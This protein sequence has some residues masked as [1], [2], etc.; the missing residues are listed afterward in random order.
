MELDERQCF[1][2]E[3]VPKTDFWTTAWGQM[4]L[5]PNCVVDHFKFIHNCSDIFGATKDLQVCAGDKYR[6]KITK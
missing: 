4:L 1:T 5:D 2:R 3:R 6:I